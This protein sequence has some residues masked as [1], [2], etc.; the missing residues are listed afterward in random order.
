MVSRHS[1]DLDAVLEFDADI[2]ERSFEGVDT[3]VSRSSSRF[4]E[5]AARS[6]IMSPR[7][8]P[9]IVDRLTALKEHRCALLRRQPESSPRSG[10][11]SERTRYGG[12][13]AHMG[14]VAK[15]F[16]AID[17]PDRLQRAKKMLGPP[18]HRSEPGAAGLMVGL[19]APGERD[20]RS[21]CIRRQL[22]ARQAY[23]ICVVQQQR[24][25][26]SGFGMFGRRA[27]PGNSS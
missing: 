12:P 21:I 5:R 4:S 22:A 27:V 13:F 19:T 10:S 8:L 24:C 7:L 23:P 11:T 3:L 15:N 2:K 25:R 17:H 1:D 26:R 20:A 6:R 14:S 18:R 16:A 9:A